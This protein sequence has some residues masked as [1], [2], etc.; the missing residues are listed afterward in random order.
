MPY[1]QVV[2]ALRRAGCVAAEEEATLLLEATGDPVELEVLLARRVA[3]LPL[4]QVLGWAAF[5]GMRVAVAPGVFVP[6]ARTALLVRLAVALAPPGGRVVDLC[7]GSGAVAAAVSAARPDLEVHAADVDPAAVA[8]ARRNLPGGRVHLGDLFDAL[9]P[10]LRGTVDVVVANA[11]YVPTDEVRLM[12]REARL[13]EPR[14]ALDG[15]ADGLDVQRR[16]AA[17]VRDWLAPGGR[18][19]VET[20]EEQAG[21]SAGLLRARGLAAHVVRGDD[22]DATAVQAGPVRS[23]TQGLGTMQA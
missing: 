17:A 4:E 8:C 11:P 2:D 14:V 23:P 9:P 21:R 3:G 5:C 10:D 12:P 19:L 16:V 22:L 15:G 6:R 20:S 13:H 18:V 7:C 1:E